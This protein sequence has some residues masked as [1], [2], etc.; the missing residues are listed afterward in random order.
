MKPIRPRLTWPW[1]MGLVGVTSLA[2]GS[3]L[4]TEGVRNY[5]HLG[6]ASAP[7]N[8]VGCADSRV[9]YMQ[10][11]EAA[12]ADLANAEAEEEDT[13]LEPIATPDRPPTDPASRRVEEPSP[14]TPR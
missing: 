8:S 13:D 11:R 2:L 1:I 3:A 10:A 14:A 4:Q 9:A 6:S 7:P 12:E 5:C